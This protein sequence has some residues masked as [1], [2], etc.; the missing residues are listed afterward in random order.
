MSLSACTQCDHHT[1]SFCTLHII[2]E[3]WLSAAKFTGVRCKSGNKLVVHTP[4]HTHTPTHV[5]TYIHKPCT[6]PWMI[7]PLHFT[8]HFLCACLGPPIWLPVAKRLFLRNRGTTEEDFTSLQL[9]Q[10]RH[11]STSSSISALRS[12]YNYFWTCNWFGELKL[13]KPKSKAV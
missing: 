11:K 12:Q 6:G 2:G 8:L 5:R 4:R 9:M 1:A 7:H 13:F 3:Y 10:Q